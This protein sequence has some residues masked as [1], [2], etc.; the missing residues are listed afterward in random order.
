MLVLLLY[1]NSSN[2]HNNNTTKKY[3]TNNK[4]NTP[5]PPYEGLHSEVLGCPS[6]RKCITTHWDAGA[7]ANAFPDTGLAQ[8]HGMQ[9]YILG[10][11]NIRDCI[12]LCLGTIVSGNGAPY[13]GVSG[14]RECIPTYWATPVSA[15]ASNTHCESEIFS[16]ISFQSQ[17]IPTNLRVVVQTQ[18]QDPRCSSGSC[19]RRV[20]AKPYLIKQGVRVRTR[21]R[22]ILLLSQHTSCPTQWLN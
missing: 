2:N 13:T 9:A 4:N 22:A 15:G 19:Y 21:V 8:Y 17:T 3:N 7:F 16:P 20:R 5:T 1:N 18:F 12:R 11:P 14:F 6:V 10:C